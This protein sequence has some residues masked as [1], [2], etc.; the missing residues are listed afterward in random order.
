MQ[1]HLFEHFSEEQHH[2]FPDNISI[3]LIDKTDPSSPL[4]REHNWIN[5]VAPH[6]GNWTLKAASEIASYH[7]ICMDCSKD[8]IHGNDFGT[9]YYC[10]YFHHYYCCCHFYHCVTFI[11]AISVILLLFFLSLILVLVWLSSLLLSFL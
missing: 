6:H 2:S 8:F 1:Q 4:Q 5:T 9:C 7:W 10:Y 3:T 11:V